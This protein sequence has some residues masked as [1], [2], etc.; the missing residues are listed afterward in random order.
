[1][2]RRGQDLPGAFFRLL[3]GL[4]FYEPEAPTGIFTDLTIQLL[5]KKLPRLL[6]REA[7]DPFGLFDLLLAK[8][9]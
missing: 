1:L 4:R 8:L 2:H 6:R 3:F 5:E 9:L 7:G